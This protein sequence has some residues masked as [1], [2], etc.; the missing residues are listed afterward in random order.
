MGLLQAN[1][2]LKVVLGIGDP[3]VG[4]LLLFDALDGSFSELRL[5]RDPKCP[6]RSDEARVARGRGE[7]APPPAF[8]AD[9]PFALGG[10]FGGPSIGGPPS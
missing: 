1:E 9:Q 6:T 3:L 8:G 10:S 7:W 4:R 2:V 5:S